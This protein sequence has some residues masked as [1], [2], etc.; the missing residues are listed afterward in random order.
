MTQSF[1][2]SSGGRIDRQH[3]L[4]FSFDGRSYTGYAGDTLASALLANGVHLVGRSFKYHRPRGILSAGAEEPN[5]LVQVGGGPGATPNLRSTQVELYDGL[6]AQSQNRF[7][8]LN[9]D[10]GALIDF[11]S[12]VLPVGFYYKTFMWPASGWKRIYEPAIRAMAGLGRAPYTADLDAY[13][14]RYAHCDVLVV[15]AGPAGIA[16]ALAAAQAG[17]R[18]ILCDEQ[19]EAGGSILSERPDT[20]LG[21]VAHT[22]RCRSLAE[23]A[24]LSNVTMLA[25]TTAYGVF[26]RNFVG[27]AERVTDRADAVD[28]N[29]PRERLW[30]VRARQIVLATGAIERPLSFA[31]NDRPGVMLAGAGRTYVNRYGV[32][33]GTCVVLVTSTDEAY[34]AILDLHEAGLQVGAIAD[35]RSDAHGPLPQEARK[36]GI[37]IHVGVRRLRT[38]GRRRVRG[39]SI[40]ASNSFGWQ[41]LTCDVLLMSGGFTPSVHLFSQARGTLAFAPGLGAFIPESDTNEVLSAGACRGIMSHRECILDG[42]E[43]G[44]IAARRVGSCE[45]SGDRTVVMAADAQYEAVNSTPQAS[46]FVDFQNDVTAGDLVLAVR[47][48]FQSIEHVKRYTTV[49]MATDQ[50]KT[51]NITALNTVALSRGMA[52]PDVGLTT[53]RM[54]YTPIT[55]GALAGACRGPLFDPIR[56]TPLHDRAEQLGAVFED[57]GQW[58]RARFFPQNDETMEQAVARECGAVRQSVGM[59]DSSTLGKIEVNGP[60]AA[61]FLE[62]MYVNTIRKLAVGRARYAV[63]LGEDGFILDDGVIGR[64]A[65]DHFYVTTTTGGAARVLATME[66]Y[67]QTEWHDLHVWLT[68]VTEEW[69]VIALQGPRSHDLIAPLVDGIDISPGSFPHMS[70]ATGQILGVPLRLFRVSFT[71]ELGF[72]LNVPADSAPAIWETLWNQGLALGVVPYGTEAM[73]VLRAEKGYI[74]IGQ[75]TDGTVTLDDVGLSWTIGAGKGDFIG[76]RS[77]QRAAMRTPDRKQLVGLLTDDPHTI[78]EEGIQIIANLG[79]ARPALGHV[80]SSYASATLKRSIALAMVSGGR[81]RIGEKVF[82]PTQSARVRATISAT[83]FYDPNGARLHV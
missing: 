59:F 65:Q 53:F 36:R 5:A 62:R 6:A 7:P 10:I 4:R 83:P 55:F 22:W 77:L 34:Q 35:M 81:Q 68:S 78:L 17:A 70:L 79:G 33:L 16:A 32:K 27:L 42:T 71:G 9:F 15:G 52:L 25:R 26:S 1:R 45:S 60:D 69:A 14:Q 24:A 39:M 54:P 49:G 21:G 38:W 2:I 23:L 28:A 80:T 43:A 66:D 31:G 8:S 74:V 63:M 3:V 29:L 56:R 47:E 11:L 20:P 57:V 41:N 44:W 50:G 18:T 73:H 40:Y 64:L 37:P 72:E 76:K 58:K 82:V 51:S 13:A 30:H 48:G 61:T 19:M 75:D 46:A 67:L 12:P